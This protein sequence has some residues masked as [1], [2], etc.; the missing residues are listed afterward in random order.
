[1]VYKKK[2]KNNIIQTCHLK[3]PTTKS[4]KKKIKT[5]LRGH[6]KF[7]VNEIASA[8]KTLWWTIR[9]LCWNMAKENMSGTGCKRCPRIPINGFIFFF[10]KELKRNSNKPASLVAQ[11][12]ACK[13]NSLSKEEKCKYAKKAKA[14]TAKRRKEQGCPVPKWMQVKLLSIRERKYFIYLFVCYVYVFC[15]QF[16]RLRVVYSCLPWNSRCRALPVADIVTLKQPCE[17][18]EASRFTS[19]A[20][21]APWGV[22]RHKNPFWKHTHTH[23][24]TLHTHI[25]M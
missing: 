5:V 10:L 15:L 2:K 14:F 9:R 16:C 11:E 4:S 7:P 1:M 17:H 19:A 24:H 12:A 3:T 21:D 23:T 20:L 8:V 18:V 25:V 13:W 6:P 22:A